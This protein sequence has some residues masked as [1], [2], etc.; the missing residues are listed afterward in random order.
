M[1]ALAIGDVLAGLKPPKQ[2]RS[3]QP[4]WRNSYY[5]GTIED[6]IFRPFMG[7]NMRAAKRHIGAILKSAKDLER[8]TRRERQAKTPGTRNGILGQVGLD[9]LDALYNRFLDYRTGRLEPS[10]AA[11][12]DAVSH[13]YSA[14]HSALMRL[15]QC[16]FLHWVRRSRP[17]DN[18]GVAG[19]Q[20]EQ[21]PNA[22]ALLLP[23]AIEGMVKHLIGK[24]PVPD[25]ERWRREQHI[26]EWNQ[27]LASVSAVEFLETTWDGDRLAGESLRRIAAALDAREKQEREFSSNGETGYDPYSKAH[28]RSSGCRRA[29]I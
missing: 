20:V 6:R 28:L 29:L 13:S 14:V 17:T 3:G 12:A 26:Q 1:T 27:M 23:K 5:E 25:D 19:P 16:G 21:I 22:Y 7:G 8:K 15:R 2:N 24:S 9:V 11:I 10:I 4:V 18:R